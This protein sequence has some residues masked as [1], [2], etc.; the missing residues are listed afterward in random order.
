MN[1]AINI[2]NL[3]VSFQENT[4]SEIIL[5]PTIETI[6]KEI[7][8]DKYKPQI[9]ALRLSLENGD[10]EFYDNY[11]KKLP[12][13]TFSATFN[14]R[15]K[16][17][18]LKNYNSLIVIDIDKL[19]EE[20]IIENYNQLLKDEYVIAFWR[21]PSNKG[22]KGLVAID[23]RVDNKEKNELE[24][25]HKSAFK[26]LSDYFLI[27][28]NIELD[29]SGSDITRLCF[30]SFDQNAVIKPNVKK[31]IIN[32]EDI[33]LSNKKEA[34]KKSDQKF[35]SSK[36][37]LYNHNNRNKPLDRKLMSDII[38]Y[39]ANKQLSITYT[40]KEWCKVAMTIA[41]TFTYDIGLNYFLKLSK[42]DSSKYDVINCTNF[43]IDCYET[44]KGNIN[45]SSIIYL[46]NQKGYK[47]KNQKNGV[48]KE[49]G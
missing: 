3:T 39:L 31:F 41:N 37:A 45:F 17:D 28:Y 21:S 25:L 34:S 13:V 4:W 33:L 20:Q 16:S 23:F 24:K 43:L 35:I 42:L 18:N 38:R 15:R 32:N 22:F 40:Y 10:H 12:A 44:R 49:E 19:Q 5:E 46:A 47:T 7:K 30:L 36:D 6:L 48:P 1:K 8:S 14:Q 9:S 11:K 27:N 26:K 29:N 2:L